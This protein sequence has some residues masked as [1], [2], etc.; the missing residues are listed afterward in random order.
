MKQDNALRRVEVALEQAVNY[1]EHDV[2]ARSVISSVMGLDDSS[3]SL[4]SFFGLL[5]K[6]REEAQ[7][8]KNFER[9]AR[10]IRRLNNLYGLLLKYDLDEV[11]WGTVAAEVDG[12]GILDSLDS[13]ANYFHRQNPAVFLESDFLETLSDEIRS[14]LLLVQES[15]LSR[16]LKVLLIQQLEGILQ[17][18]RRYEIEGT[19]GLKI[20]VKSII[21]DLVVIEHELE[22]RDKQSPI[23]KKVVGWAGALLLY[24]A[25]PPNVWDLIGAVP[26]VNEFWVPKIEELLAEQQRVESAFD[27]TST[28]QDVLARAAAIMKDQPQRFLEGSAEQKALPPADNEQDLDSSEDGNLEAQDDK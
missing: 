25:P 26:D 28:V 6:A 24:L 19:K 7:S 10:Y 9:K 20:S 2:S 16:T 14:V 1:D 4:V 17:A 18:I 11:M 8:L 27:N 22:E 15:E 21:A 3:L 13:L 12:T 23:Y 5:D